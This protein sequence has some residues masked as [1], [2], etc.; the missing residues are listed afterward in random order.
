MRKTGRVFNWTP[1]ATGTFTF[2]IRVTD[3]GSPV[4]FDEEQ[5]TVTVVTAALIAVPALATMKPNEKTASNKTGLYPNPVRNKFIVTLDQSYTKVSGII[6]NESGAVV[7][8]VMSGNINATKLEI[9]VSSLPAGTYL[10]KL[11]NGTK[12]WAFKF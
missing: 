1:T 8:R 6:T 10:L 2:K 7:K 3:N 4:L 11:D 9:E 12:S 5:I